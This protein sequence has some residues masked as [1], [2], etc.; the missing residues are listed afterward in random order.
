LT[1]NK[2][3]NN[4][5]LEIRNLKTYFF[6]GRRII[7]AV[8]GVDFNVRKGEMLGIVGESGSGKSVTAKSIMKLISNPG[9]IISGQILFEGKDLME[10]SEQEM[11]NIRGK[12]MSMIFQEPLSALN[13]S[14]S[15]GWQ[16]SEVYRLHNDM[17]KKQIYDKTIEMLN[18]VKIPDPEKRFRE[19]PHQFSGGMRQRALIAIALACN[20]EILFADEPT[21]A[22]DVTV[23]ANIMD[24]LEELRSIMKVS[25]VLISHNLNLVAER[26]SRVI[27]MYGGKIQEMANVDTIISN[28][29]HPYTIGLM[30]SIPDIDDPHQKLVAI[31]GEVFDML[32]D[33]KGCSFLKR[34]RFATPK[35][36]EKEPELIEVGESHYCRC[37][38]HNTTG[39]LESE[40][41]LN[42]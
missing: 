27:V 15:I 24:L 4:I 3:K 38:M 41:M 33:I 20:P 10:A 29:L 32:S 26:C 14:F 35:C 23:Q 31:P 42:G 36:K 25:I 18:K 30:N 16:I 9:K 1:N 12:K 13:P 28:P 40:V 19:Y 39:K 22:L 7:K 5:C 17:T 6:M 21:T 2:S 34:C 11:R 37:H 8:N